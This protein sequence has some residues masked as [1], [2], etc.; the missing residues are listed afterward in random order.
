MKKMDFNVRIT[1]WS[2]G[3]RM[4]VT[5]AG[6]KASVLRLPPSALLGDQVRCQRAGVVW[7]FDKQVPTVGFK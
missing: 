3:C 6:M 1:P 4:D 7:I 2:L 5:V